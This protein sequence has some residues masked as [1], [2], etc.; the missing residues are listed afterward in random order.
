MVAQ[1]LTRGAA[2]EVFFDAGISQHSMKADGFTL[3]LR[4]S[5]LALSEC[6][7]LE[8]PRWGICTELQAAGRTGI[9]LS[10]SEGEG[11]MASALPDWGTCDTGLGGQ[12]SPSSS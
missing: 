5:L 9:L 3:Y 12:R 2:G 6:R 10:R 1:V 4:R 8:Q 11:G 7:I